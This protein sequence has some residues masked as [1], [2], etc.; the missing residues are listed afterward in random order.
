MKM[1]RKGSSEFYV[2]FPFLP[3]NGNWLWLAGVDFSGVVDA[4]GDDSGTVLPFGP[5]PIPVFTERRVGVNQSCGVEEWSLAGWLTGVGLSESE[6]ESNSS[7][8]S[9]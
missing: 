3:R 8:P 1:K 7:Q 5:A 9:K 6:S 2:F 4:D